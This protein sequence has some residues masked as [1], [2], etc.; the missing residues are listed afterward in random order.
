[1]NAKTTKIVKPKQPSTTWVSCYN[2]NKETQHSRLQQVNQTDSHDHGRIDTNC[3]YFIVEC[4]GCGTVSFME[5]ATSS[6]DRF[7]DP[8][9]GDWEYPITRTLYPNRVVGH[10]LIED[11]GLLPYRVASIYK[12]TH[13]A[14]CSQLLILAGMGLRATLEMICVEK[15]IID[16]TLYAKINVLVE[17]GLITN[18][19]AH[20]LH[21]IREIGNEAAHEG[22]SN[23]DRVLGIALQVLEHLLTSV[24]IFP[25]KAS[26]IRAKV[27]PSKSS[28]TKGQSAKMATE[29]PQP[30]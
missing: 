23:S 9:T 20:I 27:K 28:A 30:Q 12:E 3:D 16:G 24:Y 21:G 10:A 25:Q 22:I 11:I 15:Q 1:M 6:E 17:K 2:C 29:P 19:S 4:R 7:D 5:E 18:D 8:N 13:A 14:V 26:R